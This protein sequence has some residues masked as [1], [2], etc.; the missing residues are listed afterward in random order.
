[1]KLIQYTANGGV[2][3]CVCVCVRQRP[4]KSVGLCTSCEQVWH[5]WEAAVVDTALCLV[6][7]SGTQGD[8]RQCKNVK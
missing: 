4:A 8:E 1:M 3:V 5:D 7:Q 2:F 6:K